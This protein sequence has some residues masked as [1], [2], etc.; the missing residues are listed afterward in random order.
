MNHLLRARLPSLLALS[1]VLGS[2]TAA[3]AQTLRGRTID[4]SNELLMAD[5]RVS[6]VHP[7][8][9][10]LKETLS[11]EDG[12]FSIV[13]DSAG[14]YYLK[15]EIPRYEILFDGVF[16]LGENGLLEVTLYMR[17]APVVLEGFTAEVERQAQDR[18]RLRS[19]GF[20]QRAATG[21]G[22]FID[23]EDIAKRP[24]FQFSD[25]LRGIPGIIYSGDV[26][27]FRGQGPNGDCTPNVYI[28]GAL[29]FGGADL[30][31]TVLPDD[32]AG[33]EVYRRVSETPLQWG[34]F[35][36]SCGTIVVWTKGGR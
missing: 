36:G 12:T 7:D 30:S 10:I 23:S 25:I 35:N 29:Q 32:V 9:T 14:D 18:R 20:Y 19:Q 31:A 21:F 22:R 16:E 33:V 1:I 34:G 13:A 27:Q 17:P 2:A 6:L 28:D 4:G 24:V 26:I 3:E 15:A 11:G 5:V 8:G